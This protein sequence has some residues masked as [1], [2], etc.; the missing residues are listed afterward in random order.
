MSDHF[1]LLLIFKGMLIRPNSSV[2]VKEAVPG[3]FCNSNI[4]AWNEVRPVTLHQACGRSHFV[5]FISE[6]WTVQTVTSVDAVD[7]NFG[8]QF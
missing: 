6:R 4:A 3:L 7:G 2:K 5:L 1:R 8:E